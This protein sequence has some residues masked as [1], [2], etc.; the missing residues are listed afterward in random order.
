MVINDILVIGA[1]YTGAM[2]AAQL[3][4]L[5]AHVAVVDAQAVATGATRRSVGLATPSLALEQFAETARGLNALTQIADQHGVIPVICS[6]LHVVSRPLWN[7]QLRQRCQQLQRIDNTRFGWETHPDAVPNGY[8]AGIAVAHSMQINLELLTVKLLQHENISVHPGIEINEL[9]HEKGVMHAL[10]DKYT[11]RAESVVLATNAYCGSLSPYLSDSI[12]FARGTTW[13]SVPLDAA[14]YD[15]GLF[16]M[17]VIVDD[18]QLMV[19]RGNDSRLR[20]TAWNLQESNIASEHDPAQTIRQFIEQQAPDLIRETER[21]QS[22]VTTYSLDGSP[23]V[24]QLPV[25]GRVYYALAA[26]QYGLAWGPIIAERVTQLVKP[27]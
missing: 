25:E 20:I 14:I 27:A 26:G 6:A 7:D 18:G 15:A 10:A 2:I 17:P 4:A 24:D 11:L 13:T 16:A 1:G 12:H 22:G 23:I 8:G 5:G 3:A 19:A 9:H 21:W